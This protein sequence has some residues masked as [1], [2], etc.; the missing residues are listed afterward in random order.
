MA[1]HAVRPLCLTLALTIIASSL[2]SQSAVPPRAAGITAADIAPHVAVLATDSM[3][4]RDTPSP[5][6]ERGAR[7]LAQE[8]E[9]LGLRPGVESNGSWY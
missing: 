9:R 8:F 5:S 4:D 3:A 2:S 1:H 6:L 7:Y